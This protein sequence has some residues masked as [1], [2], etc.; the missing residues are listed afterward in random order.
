MSKSL[1]MHLAELYLLLSRDATEAN[2]LFQAD[3]EAITSAALIDWDA[4][5]F[6][7]ATDWDNEKVG[8]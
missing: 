8:I 5:Q 4:S 2:S 7:P 6:F 3:G 1:T